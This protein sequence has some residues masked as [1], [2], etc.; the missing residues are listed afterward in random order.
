MYTIV[1]IHNFIRVY[2]H[3]CVCVYIYNN[4]RYLL[5]IYLSQKTVESLIARPV[6]Q[7]ALAKA[8]GWV[9]QKIGAKEVP[10]GTSPF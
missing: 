3:T 1:I 5:Y 4:R 7:G 2:T 10:K 8:L 6:H 9:L